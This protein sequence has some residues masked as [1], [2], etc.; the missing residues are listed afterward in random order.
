MAGGGGTAAR[1]ESTMN[2]GR[3]EPAQALRAEYSSLGYRGEVAR[4]LVK[5]RRRKADIRSTA[6]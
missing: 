1:T 6:S 4:G 5:M 3:V 2:A